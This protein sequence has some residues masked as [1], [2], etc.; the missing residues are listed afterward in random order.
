MQKQR[1]IVVLLLMVCMIFH[2]WSPAFSAFSHSFSPFYSFVSYPTEDK[3]ETIT[4]SMDLTSL[5]ISHQS[6]NQAAIQMQ[7]FD[8]I[9]VPGK[10]LL[11]FQQE[12]IAIEDNY[13]LLSLEL[14]SIKSENIELEK[15]SWQCSS[16]PYIMSIDQQNAN[17]QG[18][19][20]VSFST[21]SMEIDTEYSFPPQEYRILDP[22]PT[23]GCIQIHLYPILYQSPSTAEFIKEITIQVNF[24]LKTSQQSV[25]E[26]ASS[27]GI[28]KGLIIAPD[29]FQA[30]A[31][32]LQ[33]HQLNNGVQSDVVFTSDISYRQEFPPSIQEP[34]QGY[35]DSHP[36]YLQLYD[37]TLAYQIRDCIYDHYMN[38]E[39]SIQYVTL[40][41]DA[42]HI[43]PSYYIFCKDSE[44]DYEKWI[45]TDLYY[46][47]FAPDSLSIQPLLSIGR[48]PCNNESE[49]MQMVHN[50]I[51]NQQESTLSSSFPIL[52]SGGDPFR[53]DPYFAELVQTH[54]VNQ[55]RVPSYDIEK[56]FTTTENCT[57]TKLRQQL[58]ESSFPLVWAFGHGDGSRL[59]LDQGEITSHDLSQWN[60]GHNHGL[61][62]SEGCGNA[63]FDQQLLGYKK[64]P[65]FGASLLFSKSGFTS[66]FGSTR[67]CWCGWDF[68]KEKGSPTVRKVFYGEAII[69]YFL[70]E[71]THSETYGLAT[72]NAF[73][74]YSMV[75]CI[76]LNEPFLKTLFGFTFL[77]D[78]T[79][80]NPFFQKV[81]SHQEIMIEKSNQVCKDFETIPAFSVHD[82]MN[83]DLTSSSPYI[84]LF[85]YHEDKNTLVLDQIVSPTLRREQSSHY[86]NI[87]VPLPGKG[88]FIV[89]FEMENGQEKRLYIQGKKEHDLVLIPSFDLQLLSKGERKDYSFQIRND[90]FSEEENVRISIVE[91]NQTIYRNV[92][93]T[94][95]PY[96]ERH[97]FFS[98]VPTEEGEKQVELS[99]VGANQSVSHL[100]LLHVTSQ[101]ITR[102]G[103]LCP[104]NNNERDIIQQQLMI[105]D[106]NKDLSRRLL[107]IELQAVP[108][109]P[110]DHGFTT[111]DRLHFD[112]LMV[113][114]QPQLYQNQS[115]LMYR[116]VEFE[117][118]GGLVCGMI[119]FGYSQSSPQ[120][121][122]LLQN[123]F[124][125]HENEKLTIVQTINNEDKLHIQ[126]NRWLERFRSEYR[127]STPYTLVSLKTL[128]S[129]IQLLPGAV[130]MGAS[131]NNDH[132]LIEYKNR[133]LFTGYLNT[134]CF[135]SL[136]DSYTFFL[137]FFQFARNQWIQK[138]NQSSSL[139]K[140]KHE[141]IASPQQ[142]HVSQ[143]NGTGPFAIK[144]PV[145]PTAV[146]SHHDSIWIATIHGFYKTT[147]QKPSEFTFYRYPQELIR[148]IGPKVFK[149]MVSK[150]SRNRFRVYQ[151]SIVFYGGNSF[152][153]FRPDMLSLGIQ[154]IPC[155]LFDTFVMPIEQYSF[156]VDFEIH[157]QWLYVLDRNNLITVVD[158]LSGR[159]LFRFPHSQEMGIDLHIYNERVYVL[160]KQDSIVS[161][162]LQGLNASSIPLTKSVNPHSFFISNQGVIYLYCEN[163]KTVFYEIAIHS[164]NGSTQNRMQ[165][166]FHIQNDQI[167]DAEQFYIHQNTLIGMFSTNNERDLLSFKGICLMYDIDN[168]SSLFQTSMEKEYYT[169]I[170]HTLFNSDCW[171]AH[172]GTVIVQQQKPLRDTID[173]YSPDTF[174]WQGSIVLSDYAPSYTL[175]GF[176][177]SSYHGM[178]HALYRS[179]KDLL[180]VMMDPLHPNR[181]QKMEISSRSSETIQSIAVFQDLILMLHQDG[182]VEVYNTDEK[183]TWNAFY[184]A[185]QTKEKYAL[186]STQVLVDQKHI[187]LIDTKGNQFFAFTY[188]GDLVFCHSLQ[189]S[190]PNTY[191][192]AVL[193]DT[194]EVALLNHNE[195]M[196]QLILQG[197]FTRSYTIE[198][199]FPLSFQTT[200]DSFLIVDFYGG[201][202]S[203]SR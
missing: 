14:V 81:H 96:G 146:Q 202:Q 162:T 177:Y 171:V 13:Q 139:S 56:Q 86:Y 19:D 154:E 9:A 157:G 148:K 129:D 15:G 201:I 53:K 160:L 75:D 132:A 196:I 108:F 18:S 65:S 111:F 89:R 120:L 45:P 88:N 192:K 83:I 180:L 39:N 3:T 74:T 69:Q 116:L 68:R 142:P 91:K 134:D 155:T 77:G 137:D 47:H 16:D 112:I 55:H 85:L 106:I 203:Y 163:E 147:I 44:T 93:E 28:S 193:L 60:S 43:P 105:E 78:P 24:T 26:M 186:H 200:K 30:A 190:I 37:A 4:F 51:R 101:P 128:W 183:R 191:S 57:A 8:C 21:S 127:L 103:I 153:V 48:I 199:S 54:H 11:W 42:A 34:L 126:D 66:Y 131:K 179:D 185:S 12:A 10:P 133:I 80:P 188:T 167:G 71:L 117:Q 36:L 156:V 73:Q 33:E 102:I 31:L 123:Y 158:I 136:D 143:S 92:L 7:D 107:N 52:L 79:T 59:L 32:E 20:L 151:N 175:I 176:T 149:E 17:F 35:E 104:N 62:I 194:G 189:A 49:A 41:G 198:N 87:N 187:Y 135:N 40:L 1:V 130:L 152:Y 138:Q 46:S 64:E 98:Y 144:E 141:Q 118:K 182:L 25:R 58:Q 174:Y 5:T 170:N 172:D 161:Y 114:S 67:D 168:K 84:R 22:Y 184:P 181:W 2:T 61:L 94:I 76:E 164:S 38:Q 145:F 115:E 99:V 63:S 169:N 173:M 122:T 121:N 6:N 70:E 178:I 23:G 165:E 166:A 72:K 97:A 110:D 197:K 195:N 119:P 109:A 159:M 50:M 90:G 125:I 124:G 100:Q 95:P 150:P 29:S 27:N 113:F 82:D 140:T